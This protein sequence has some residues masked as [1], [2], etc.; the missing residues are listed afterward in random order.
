MARREL[1]DAIHEYKSAGSAVYGNYK[2]MD[3]V[4]KIEKAIDAEIKS[5]KTRLDAAEEVVEAARNHS[6]ICNKEDREKYHAW[7]WAD[8]VECIEA[9]ACDYLST[10][11]ALK[12]YDEAK[13]KDSR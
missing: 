5:L 6:G 11:K 9:P 8:C 12:A 4:V 7:D 2:R 3:A 1:W 13:G 10:C